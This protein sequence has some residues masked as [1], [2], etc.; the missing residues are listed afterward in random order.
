MNLTWHKSNV[1]G[2]F[3]AAFLQIFDQRSCQAAK[4]QIR[5]IGHQSKKPCSLSTFFD[6]CLLLCSTLLILNMVD[7]LTYTIKK[8]NFP[9]GGVSISG[10]SSDSRPQG[11]GVEPSDGR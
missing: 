11:G 1:Q 6:F 9:N 7:C 4:L 5:N 3:L 8:L 2:D 10:G